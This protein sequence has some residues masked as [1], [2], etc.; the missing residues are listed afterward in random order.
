MTGQ[1]DQQHVRREY[2]GTGLYWSLVG[3]AVL[4]V[5]ILIGIVQN[6]QT[7][8]LKYLAWDVRTPLIVVLLI[9]ITATAVLTELVGMIWRRRRR[10]QLT[11]HEELQELRTLGVAP[12]MAP[13]P[14]AAEPGS[15]LTS[16]SPPGL[17]PPQ[18][19]G[20]PGSVSPR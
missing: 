5:A 2:R 18:P 17:S 9:A 15:G 10:R 1:R 6:G 3:A 8:E 7:V 13:P 14:P 4:G 11:E 19:P 20:D 16:A 12:A